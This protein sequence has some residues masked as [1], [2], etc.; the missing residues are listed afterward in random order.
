M[1]KLTN[2][3]ILDAHTLLLN[4][5]AKK[6]DTIDLNTIEHIDS[7]FLQNKIEEALETAYK[8]RLQDKEKMW[9]VDSQNKLQE[10]IQS[11]NTKITE[12]ETQLKSE[13]DLVRTKLTSEFALKIAELQNQIDKLNQEKTSLQLQN[14][15]NI[16]LALS[17]KDNEFSQEISRY[18]Q[19]IAKLK[20]LQVSQ[21][22][23]SDI[24]L[25]SA[26][27]KKENELNQLINEKDQQIQ[28]LSLEKSSLNIKKMGEE[29]E[30][31]VNEEYQ[32]HAMNGFET[33]LWEKDNLAIKSFGETK[34]TKADYIFRVFASTD[35][36][37]ENALTSVACEIK[38]EDPHSTYKKKNADHYDKLD[39]DR[40]KKG[41][42]YALLISE[43]EWESIN[44][45]PIRKVQG[46][47]KMYMVRPQYFIVFLNLV[48]AI[49]LK[50][51]E[52][53][54]GY[55][56]ERAQFKDTENIL[57]EFE[58][59]KHNILDLSVKYIDTKLTEITTSAKNIEKEAKAI[60]E[61]SRIVLERHIQ[62]IINKINQF[63]INQ[64]VDKIK[65]LDE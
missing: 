60:L 64:V 26:L 28:R 37:E 1:A 3:S 50:Y 61:A 6:G 52:V 18:K 34:G 13:Q 10:A 51:R 15:Q 29:L 62:T 24:N 53:V 8:V 21:K 46:Y 32:N 20:D 41:C 14:K 48:T 5:D 45:A 42:E 2:I 43:L 25:E 59:M 30:S 55:N 7:V 4:Q 54:K 57:A 22:E 36:T 49:A 23:L 27:N 9:Q 44:D 19:E 56:K 33:C 58:E 47:D 12:L 31:W 11:K 63:K 35:F 17:K 16:E 40:E 38:S 65:E 39:K